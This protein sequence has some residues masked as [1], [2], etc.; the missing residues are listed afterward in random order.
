MEEMNQITLKCPVTVKAKVT[1]TLKKQLSAEI[2]DQVKRADLELQQIEFQGK[3]MLAEQA[4]EDAQG[5]LAIR[6]QIDMEKQKRL[7]FKA[8]ATERLKEI[9]DLEIGAEIVRGNLEQI[10]TLKLG[11]NLHQAM[12]TEILLEDGKIIAFRS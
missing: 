4:K 5:L 1:E 11:D 6:Q 10:V 7:D 12:A 8:Q 9:S 3:R 2:E